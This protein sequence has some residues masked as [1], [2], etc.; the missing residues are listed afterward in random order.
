GGGMTLT[1]DNLGIS[2]VDQ[3]YFPGIGQFNLLDL[4]PWYWLILAVLLF[5]LFVNLRLRDSRLRRAWLAL[6][7][8]EIPAVAM[9]IPLVVTELLAYWIGAAFGGMAGA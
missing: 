7:G 8:D 5:V 4:R 1:A 2:A 9:G 6:R 3:P